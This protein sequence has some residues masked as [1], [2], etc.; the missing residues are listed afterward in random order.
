MLMKYHTSDSAEWRRI[1]RAQLGGQVFGTPRFNALKLFPETVFS[2]D[3]DNNLKWAI[4]G[5]D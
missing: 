3:Y 4:L 1:I 2:S 5:T